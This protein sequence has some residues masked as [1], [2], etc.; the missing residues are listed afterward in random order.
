MNRLTQTTEFK[1][2]D[3]FKRCQIC[4]FTND[5]KCE[6]YMWYE[7]DDN[8]NPEIGNIL[9]T[10]RNEKC[11]NLINKHERLYHQVPWGMGQPGHFILLCGDCKFR[12][13][14]KCTHKDLKANGGEG[15]KVIFAG[16][17]E[18][19]MCFH[20]DSSESGGL[21]CMPFEKPAAECLGKVIK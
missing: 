10:C 5:D 8:D 3:S 18:G 11:M 13:E 19:F 12:D 21:K 20:D 14:S 16:L 6:F 4:G 15:L 9:V 1:E 17:F 7:C 2:L